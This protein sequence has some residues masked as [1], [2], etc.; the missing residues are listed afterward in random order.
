MMAQIENEYS[1]IEGD[2]TDGKQYVKTVAA[3]ALGLK[4][5]IPWM[6]CSQSDAP[7]HR[8]QHLQRLLLR[9]LP[10]EPLSELSDAAAPMDGGLERSEAATCPVLQACHRPA[11]TWQ[12]SHL[13]FPLV[14][15][16]VQAGRRS[17][18]SRSSIGPLRTSTSP[19]LAGTRRAAPTT[20]ITVSTTAP[21]SS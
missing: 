19:S 12:R 9:W 4:L 15:V 11:S 7:R 14:F 17:G 16:L 20:R 8:H 1:N 10:W 6:M 5:D 3:F 13:Y 21:Q 2:K 18:E